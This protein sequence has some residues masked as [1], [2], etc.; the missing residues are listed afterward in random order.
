[1]WGWCA[2]GATAGL[3]LQVPHHLAALLL[4]RDPE[5]AGALAAYVL[6]VAALRWTYRPLWP[7]ARSTDGPKGTGPAAGAAAADR[8]ARAG[9]AGGD[10]TSPA[11]QAAPSGPGGHGH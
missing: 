7:A 1:I 6:V 10:V 8:G 5:A 9:E 2:L 3:L 11:E 4:R